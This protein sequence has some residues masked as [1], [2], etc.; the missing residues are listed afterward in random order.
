MGTRS[1]ISGSSTSRDDSSHQKALTATEVENAIGVLLLAMRNL[2]ATMSAIVARLDRLE[3]AHFDDR[4]PA[5]P[6]A[7]GSLAIRSPESLPSEHTEDSSLASQFL[8]WVD[9]ESSKPIPPTSHPS[10][11]TVVGFIAISPCDTSVQ[12]LFTS[13]ALES[14][15][16][17]VEFEDNNSGGLAEKAPAHDKNVAKIQTVFRLCAVRLRLQN[18]C[19]LENLT[20]MESQ[21]LSSRTRFTCDCSASRCSSRHRR[22]RR[23]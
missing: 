3:G 9:D 20:V 15:Y 11:Q 18:D 19:G 7:V 13:S 4:N 21:V 1:L 16:G 14:D 6:G 10:P 2:A 23:P 8:Q 17:V 5:D 12:K 22:F